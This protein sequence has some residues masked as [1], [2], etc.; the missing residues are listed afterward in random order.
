[1]FDLLKVHENGLNIFNTT[2]NEC[3]T[4]MNLLMT[5]ILVS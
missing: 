2:I 5:V 1:M 3:I 4:H